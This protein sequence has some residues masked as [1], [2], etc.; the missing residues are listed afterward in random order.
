LTDLYK[1]VPP[2]EVL[3]AFGYAISEDVA[4]HFDVEQEHIASKADRLL[5][6]L[7]YLGENLSELSERNI[8][9]EDFS[10]F[11][12]E[13]YAN[14]GIEGF[15]IIQKLSQ[16]VPVEMSEQDF[17]SRCKTLNEIIVR[18][19][20]GPLKELLRSFKCPPKDVKSLGSLKLMQGLANILS[21]LNHGLENAEALTDSADHI[22]WK[23]KNQ[24]MAPL[25][26]NYDLRLDDAHE[27]I[28]ESIV[29][30][31]ALGFDSRSID[32]GYGLAFDFILDNVIQ[33]IESINSNAKDILSR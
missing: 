15:T 23:A 1:A 29:K 2:Q 32:A 9:P 6:E 31:E 27:T 25:F 19:K 14:K 12:R 10:E 13:I 26:I 16:V 28:G 21:N 8:A 11:I 7:I 18:I 4:N 24:S 30:L 17:L 22:D 33:T 20:P 3:H 5:N